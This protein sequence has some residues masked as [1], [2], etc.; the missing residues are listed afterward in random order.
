MKLLRFHATWC[1]P[2]KRFEPILSAFA[3]KHGIPV[4]HVDIE[5]QP[6]LATA[7]DIRSVPTTLVIK[8]GEVVKTINGAMPTPVLEKEMAAFI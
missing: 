8:D 2:C 5:E 3:E 6:D 1:Q 4:Q 7:Y